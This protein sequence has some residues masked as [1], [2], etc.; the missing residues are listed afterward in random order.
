VC[1]F[2]GA[3]RREYGISPGQFRHDRPRLMSAPA[4]STGT[5]A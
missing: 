5:V 2:A 4:Q 1:P 3:F